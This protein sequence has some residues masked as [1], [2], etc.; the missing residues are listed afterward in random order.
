MRVLRIAYRVVR[1]ALRIGIP[2]KRV[3]HHRPSRILYTIV[4]IAPVMLE[5]RVCLAVQPE[6]APV[7]EIAHQGNQ[8]LAV[9][10]QVAPH[11]AGNARCRIEVPVAGGHFFDD[12]VQ[13]QMFILSYR[14]G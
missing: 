14:E 1:C 2:A 10:P 11:P 3:K 5:V 4:P 13:R 8:R 7:C 6:I 12:A 9:L